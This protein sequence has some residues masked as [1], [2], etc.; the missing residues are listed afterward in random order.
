MTVRFLKNCWA[1]QNQTRVHCECCG[2]EPDGCED[3]FFMAGDEEEVDNMWHEIDLTNLK[4][5]EDFLVIEL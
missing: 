1:P 5:N 4:I 2:P 3:T